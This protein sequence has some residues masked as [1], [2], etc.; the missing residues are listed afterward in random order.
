MPPALDH[1]DAWIFDLDNTLYPASADLFGLIDV[2]M[3]LYVE[4]L[5]GVD[6][7]EAK[8]IQKRMFREH[9]TTLSGLMRSHDID[10]HE[11]LAFVHDVE[12]D[13]LAEDR[14]LVEAVAKLPG[15]KLIFT[16]GDA[17]YAARVLER[18]GLSKSFEAIH[19]IHACAYQPK[20]HVASYESMVRAFGIDPTTSLF[21]EDM[22][23]NLKPAK[24][25][26]M[27]TVWVNNGS[28]LGNHDADPSFIDFEIQDVGQWLHAIT[29]GP[30]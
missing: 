1:I 3:G 13:V 30:E 16:N 26:G 22:A 28:E 25:I 17:D 7:V 27:T 11:F 12:M 9:G 14:R 20:P 24:A 6:P 15:R 18:L 29:G 19:D 4:R 2:R 21:V 23:R 5:L 10:P 8:H